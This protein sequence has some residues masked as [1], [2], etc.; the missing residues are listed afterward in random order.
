[1]AKEFTE[2][3]GYEFNPTIQ[4]ALERVYEFLI[5]NPAVPV[6]IIEISALF[7]FVVYRYTTFR[8]RNWLKPQELVKEES[9]LYIDHAKKITEETE[10]REN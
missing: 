8:F 10:N 1:M 7:S 9:E 6:S 3:A 5:D 4:N 2:M